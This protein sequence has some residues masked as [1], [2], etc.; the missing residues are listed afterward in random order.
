MLAGG[1]NV[2]IADDLTDLTVVRLANTDIRIEGN[3][4]R[5]EAGAA[6]DDVVVAALAPGSAAW[7][8]CPASPARRARR[9][10]RT[11]APTASRSPT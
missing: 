4:V 11:S 3:V 5:A 8:A 6:W 7:S 1:S 10:C 9:P 2:V